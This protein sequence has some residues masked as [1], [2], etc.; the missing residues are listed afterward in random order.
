MPVFIVD[1]L[2]RSKPPAPGEPLKPQSASSQMMTASAGVAHEFSVRHCW[3]S[4]GMS[5]D[6]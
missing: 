4:L 3:V 5:M 2:T 6:H 1:K